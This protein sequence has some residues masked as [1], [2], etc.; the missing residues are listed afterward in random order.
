[1]LDK[2]E[3]LRKQ[4]KHIRNRYAFWIALSLTLLIA[5]VWALVLSAKLSTKKVVPQEHADD[6]GSFSRS[7]SDVS[8]RVT[9]IF[10]NMRTRFEYVKEVQ[11]PVITK[12]DV[13]DLNAL[14]LATSSK[15]KSTSTDSYIGTTTNGTFNATATSLKATTTER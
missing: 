5:L 7:L 10:S 6:S 1:M 4:P 15:Q 14:L 9:E 3:A 12:P 13:L 2:I 11:P 8:E